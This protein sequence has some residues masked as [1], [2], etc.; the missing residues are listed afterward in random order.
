[1]HQIF[2]SF[3]YTFNDNGLNA[4]L[5]KRVSDKKNFNI[6]LLWI[7]LG[8]IHSKALEYTIK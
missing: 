4:Q 5:K 7:V 2:F 6:R 3:F 8:I 1:M